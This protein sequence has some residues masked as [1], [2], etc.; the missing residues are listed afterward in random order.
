MVL[1][2]TRTVRGV[3]DIVR[4]EEEDGGGEDGGEEE[5]GSGARVRAVSCVEVGVRWRA[6]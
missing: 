4:A 5:E 6:T 2:R 1:L 3:D